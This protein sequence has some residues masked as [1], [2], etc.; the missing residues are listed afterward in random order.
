MTVRKDNVGELGSNCFL[1]LNLLGDL[2]LLSFTDSNVLC[3]KCKKETTFACL[4]MFNVING[5]VIQLVHI[6]ERAPT[7]LHDYAD[8]PAFFPRVMTLIA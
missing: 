6:A 4:L 1:K 7:Q 5:R 3:C 8:L 2:L